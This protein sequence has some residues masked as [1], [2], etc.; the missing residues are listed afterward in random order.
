MPERWLIEMQKIGRMEPISDLL[1]R[2]EHGPSLPPPRPR[3]TSRVATAVV[4]VVITIA[5]G[6][7][8][9][10]ALSG[11]AGRQPL[12]DGGTAFSATWPETSLTEAQRVQA[13]VDAGDPKVQWR[14]DAAGVALRFGRVVLGWPAP[15]AGEA[16]TNDPDTVIVW[17]NGPD[18]S[19][20]GEACS[21]PS[22]QSTVTLTLRRLV[23]SGDGGIWSVTAVDGAEGMQSST[24]P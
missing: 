17:L 22:P 24:Q 2:A 15:L 9:Y 16:T 13:R 10:A 18:A 23:R 1:E 3:P 4:A 7:M 21:T 14:T 19:C 12:G 11:T 8:A 20:R 5:G 6:W